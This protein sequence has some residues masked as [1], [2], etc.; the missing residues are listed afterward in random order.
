MSFFPSYSP[1]AFNNRTSLQSKHDI[2]IFCKIKKEKLN[3]VGIPEAE[4]NEELSRRDFIEKK[5]IIR[6]ELCQSLN[7]RS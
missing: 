2:D 5:K 3:L 1:K 6:Y 7:G 4:R